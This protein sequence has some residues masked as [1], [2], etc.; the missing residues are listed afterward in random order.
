VALQVEAAG[1]LLKVLQVF[2][3]LPQDGVVQVAI[4]LERAEA[5]DQ[6]AGGELQPGVGVGEDAAQRRVPVFSASSFTVTSPTG[7]PPMTAIRRTR[8]AAASAPLA[9]MRPPRV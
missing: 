8:P 7:P 3:A 2:A 6:R 4:A 5:G 1:V 9:L